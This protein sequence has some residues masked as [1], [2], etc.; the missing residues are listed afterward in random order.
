MLVSYEPIELRCFT[1]YDLALW[2]DLTYGKIET[3]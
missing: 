1:F 2:V 3:S